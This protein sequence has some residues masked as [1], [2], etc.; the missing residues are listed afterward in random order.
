MPVADL[1]RFQ[2]IDSWIFDLDNTLYPPHADLWPKVDQKI[3]QYIAN[4]LG[5]DGLSA[6][7]IQKYYYAQHGTTL[8]GLM[9][10]HGIDPHA[11]LAFVHDI[12]R[13]NLETDARLGE[14]IARLPGRK[15]V[16]TNGSRG[17]AIKTMQALGIDHLFE[18]VFDIVSANF[19]PKPA[20]APYEGFLAAHAIDPAR[21]AMFED[22]PRNLIIP[23]EMGMACVLVVPGDLGSN[24]DEWDKAIDHAEG[25]SSP[26]YDAITHDLPDF[27][28]R[29]SLLLGKGLLASPDA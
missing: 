10:E 17:H 27:L 26:A 12:D 24:K 1:S 3:T 20:R 19:V 29:L 14:A 13:S 28:D 23:Q 16:F 8:N 15:L 22:I 11:F 7:A 5:V 25:A 18:D 2:C 4:L 21:A 9:Q 6:R